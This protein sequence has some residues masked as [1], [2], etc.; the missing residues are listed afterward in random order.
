MAE[1]KIKVYGLVEDEDEYGEVFYQKLYDKEEQVTFFTVS[2][3]NECPE[4][5]IIGRDLFDAADYIKA[6]RRGIKLAKQGYTDASFEVGD[7]E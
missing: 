5:A 4:D 6:V 7:A 2:N 3:L 1:Q